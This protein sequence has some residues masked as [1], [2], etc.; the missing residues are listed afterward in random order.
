MKSIRSS[1][2]R[3]HVTCLREQA[4]LIY[5]DYAATALTPDEVISAMN[6]Y[7]LKY[8]AN[9]H[10][11]THPW[12]IEATKAYEAARS[13]AAR[14]IGA[15]NADS[16][17]FTSGTTHGLN[18]LAYGLSHTLSQDNI[19]VLSRLEHHANLLPWQRVAE[20]TGATLAYIELTENY[21]IDIASYDALLAT[22][23]V[24]I[25]SL[26]H[27]SNVLG[28]T[29]PV[30]ILCDKARAAGA[31]SIIDGAQSVQHMPID[32]TTIGCDAFVFSGHKLYGPTGIGAMYISDTLS[33]QLQPFHLGGGM[34]TH[35]TYDTASFVPSPH[36]FEAG[37]P[38]IAG[39]IGLGV[40]ITYISSIGIGSIESHIATLNAYAIT[41]L[42][43]IPG[44]QYIGPVQN[45]SGII[46]FSIDGIHHADVAT[47]LAAQHIAIRAGHHCAEPLMTHLGLSGT[48][49]ISIGIYTTTHDIDAC[50]AAIQRIQTRI[51]T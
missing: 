51:V 39:A 42:R 23:R 9:I 30:E 4:D 27:V 12:S 18:A 31:I 48:C 2:I 24:A 26:S 16:I 25:V 36:M 1:S 22:G 49:R 47:L 37:T 28:T 8:P 45:T 17:V 20:K 15:P 13:T 44:L 40:A 19:I 7:Y 32:V 43:D 41:K 3:N 35:T 50:V 46:S 34:V 33:K 38:N 14:C 10:R 21:E 5:L 6:E 29:L 11:S